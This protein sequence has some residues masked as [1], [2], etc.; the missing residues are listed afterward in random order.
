MAIVKPRWLVVTVAAAVEDECHQTN[1]ADDREQDAEK[2]CGVAMNSDRGV[3]TF[4]QAL[5]RKKT[6][7]PASIVGD[8]TTR[9]MF[10]IRAS[11]R[12]AA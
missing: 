11:L 9:S 5:V 12:S 2:H 8:T 1:A 4:G 10:R 3:A 6:M 7:A